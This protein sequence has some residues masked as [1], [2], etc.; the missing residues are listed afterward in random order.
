LATNG[1]LTDNA[2]PINVFLV[3]EQ[4]LARTGT[5][6][7]LSS[8][9]RIRVVG[10][11]SSL[12]EAVRT[13]P[14]CDVVVMDVRPIPEA[15]RQL[16]G[17]LPDAEIVLFTGVTDE[18]SIRR[19]VHGGA[20]GFLSKTA[21]GSELARAIELVHSGE[22]Y[23]NGRLSRLDDENRQ[24]R[25]RD[26][27]MATLTPRETEVLKEVAEGR[28]SKQIALRMG[29]SV[30]TVETHRERI[31]QKVGIHSASGLTRFAIARGVVDVE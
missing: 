21:T 1:A 14:K 23:F 5:E 7:F 30:R 31:M 8:H 10:E 2:P 3:D 13:P 12:E 11:A 19:A 15:M 18:K 28:T 9:D 22:S 6:V 27:V 26:K 25:T 17:K 29:L 24:A 16:R 4:P 20:R